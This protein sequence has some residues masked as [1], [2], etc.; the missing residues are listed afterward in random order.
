MTRGLW[1]CL[2][3]G[4]ALLLLAGAAGEDTEERAIRQTIQRYFDGDRDRR[5]EPLQEAFH[6][7]ARLLTAGAAG[8]LRAM[9]QPQWYER[10]RQSPDRERPEAEILSIDRAGNAAVAKTRMIFSN[11]QFTDFLSLLKLEGRWLIVNKIY[12][13]EDH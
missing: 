2:A 8:E 13:W 7:E 12:H 10:I 1:T 4:A 3:A 11:G 6:P 9:T 5:I